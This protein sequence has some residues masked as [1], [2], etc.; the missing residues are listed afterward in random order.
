MGG[1]GESIN[2]GITKSKLAVILS[3][4]LWLCAAERLLKG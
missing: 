4:P 3:K 1:S 2:Q